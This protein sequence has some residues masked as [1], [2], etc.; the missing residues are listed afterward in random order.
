MLHM[1]GEEEKRVSAVWKFLFLPSCP[2][3]LF[4]AT[5]LNPEPSRGLPSDEHP[6]QLNLFPS[7]ITGQFDGDLSS[8][9]LQTVFHTSHVLVV[10]P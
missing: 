8:S 5:N 3:S 1:G 7:V 9:C 2:C 10:P 4:Y 6:C